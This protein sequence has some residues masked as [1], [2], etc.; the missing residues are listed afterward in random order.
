MPAARATLSPTRHTQ[1]AQERR[2]QLMQ[3]TSVMRE[4]AAALQGSGGAAG[5]K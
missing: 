2:N 5:G 1:A 4:K 3:V